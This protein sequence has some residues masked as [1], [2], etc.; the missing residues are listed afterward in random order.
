MNIQHSDVLI[1]M[2][3]LSD[4]TKLNYTYN[5][6]FGY[7]YSIGDVVIYLKHP[8][9]QDEHY[10]QVLRWEACKQGGLKSSY[11]H[12]QEIPTLDYKTISIQDN[13]INLEALYLI[14]DL[15]WTIYTK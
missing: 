4:K 14:L 2:R 13:R 1:L 6:C 10:N 3:D 7:S 12:F 11:D 5:S 8:L 15:Y 9:I